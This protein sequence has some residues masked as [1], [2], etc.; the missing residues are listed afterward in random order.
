[1]MRPLTLHALAASLL[2]ACATPPPPVIRIEPPFT[3]ASEGL[4]DLP[5]PPLPAEPVPAEEI[6]ALMP[7][8][9]STEDLSLAPEPASLKPD[10]AE[11]VTPREA[12][13][14][15][16]EANSA[17]RQRAAPGAFSE[18]TLLYAWEPGAIYELQTSPDF[19]ST[20]LLEPG[21]VLIDIAAAD[22]A[23]WSVSNTL[24]GDRALLIVKPSAPKLKTNIVLVTDRRAY[25]IEAVSAA[26][27]VYTAQAAWTYPA[28]PA[29]PPAP[30]P[31]PKPEPPPRQ[32]H[33]DYV[34]KAPRKGPPPWMPEKVWDDGRR[35][36]VQFPEDIVASDM[37]PL[38]IRTAEGLELVNYRIDGRSY[39][40]DRIFTAAELRLGRKK[41]VV[42]RILRRPPRETGEGAR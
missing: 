33:E 32:I 5:E 10:R 6:P 19:V 14:I 31:A 1:M 27:E 20:L 42:V 40:V 24:S 38:L 34:L 41:P 3:E 18:A 12:A 8:A 2:T 37:P 21:E 15:L 13:R 39:E 7:E 9:P 35:T 11:P 16:A 4:G 26:G 25:L 30:E 22:T 17:A 28:P 29:P 23:R 36:Y